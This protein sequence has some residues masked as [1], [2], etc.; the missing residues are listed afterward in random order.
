MWVKGGEERMVD[1]KC[2]NW[3]LFGSNI[4]PERLQNIKDQIKEVLSPCF[5]CLILYLNASSCL[6][7]SPQSRKQ[8][9]RWRRFPSWL[10]KELLS[11]TILLSARDC[12]DKGTT[13]CFWPKVSQ[14]HGGDRSKNIYLG[15][16]KMW[17][18]S[19]RWCTGCC[20]T[21]PIVGA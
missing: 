17:V 8:S 1:V 20:G 21:D 19:L 5:Q 7:C 4:Y 16:L 3:Q 15:K 14:P 9:T 6:T 12:A 11:T 13:E 18:L 10:L 2:N